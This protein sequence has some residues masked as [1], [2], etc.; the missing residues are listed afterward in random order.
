MKG[1]VIGLIFYKTDWFALCSASDSAKLYKR[2]VDLCVRSSKSTLRCLPQCP[3]VLRA[4][5]TRL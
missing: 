3:P 5:L 4:L 2:G 1:L